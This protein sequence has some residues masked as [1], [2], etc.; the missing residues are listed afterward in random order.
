MATL[1]D[2]DIFPYDV[3]DKVIIRRDINRHT[4]VPYSFANDMEEFRG[5]TMTI[6]DKNISNYYDINEFPI[7]QET[8]DNLGI[9]WNDGDGIRITSYRMKED[10]GEYSWNIFMFEN[11]II[12][13]RV[14]GDP[15]ELSML[16]GDIFL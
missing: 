11:Q 2:Q 10:R 12:P 1:Y 14:I 15:E 4:E 16:Y 9:N 13:K 8:L 7:I 6:F 3:D 5:K